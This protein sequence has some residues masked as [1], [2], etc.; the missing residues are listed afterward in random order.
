MFNLTLMNKLIRIELVS[1][2][3]SDRMP[4]E[5]LQKPMAWLRHPWAKNEN[6]KT[7]FI[8]RI[9]LLDGRL[10][11][12]VNMLPGSMQSNYGLWAK[13]FEKSLFRFISQ[14][15][16]SGQPL[17]TFAKKSAKCIANCQVLEWTVPGNRYTLQNNI[18]KF[19][20]KNRTHLVVRSL[21][22]IFLF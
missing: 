17:S 14:N 19:L 16:P 5:C 4:F 10:F 7:V 13:T 2:R 12:Q 8:Q 11:S 21:R 9:P 20:L 1:E 18:K 15:H 3:E 22:I 6:N